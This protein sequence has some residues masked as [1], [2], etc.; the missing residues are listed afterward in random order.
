MTLKNQVTFDDECQPNVESASPDQPASRGS[1]LQEALHRWGGPLF[2]LIVIGAAGYLFY[3][4]FR[5]HQM[6]EVLASA[7]RIPLRRYVTAIALIGLHYVILAAYEQIGLWYLKKPLSWG[8]L[9]LGTFVGYSLSLNLTW[10]L[11]GPLGRYALYKRWGMSAVEIVK[12]VALLGLTYTVG[13]LLVPGLLCL[14]EP[15]ELPTAL[16]Q[17]YHL[18]FQNTFWFGVSFLTL[19][20]LYLIL[21]ATRRG[22][23]RLWGFELQLPP[24]WLAVTHLIITAADLVV[25]ALTLYALLPGMGIEFVHLLNVVLFTMVIVYLS[26]A[27]GGVGVIEACLGVFLGQYHGPA[28]LAAAIMFRVLYFLLPLAISLGILGLVEVARRV[29]LS[30]D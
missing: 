11:G 1:A 28:V 30:K 25:M 23:L 5:E 6:A 7:R 17:K 8:R 14:W 20:T 19:G 22:T 4:Q 12:L 24:L 3:L 15:L 13:I 29:D 18:Y 10:V 9:A 21:C 26:H 2:V 16:M 27:P